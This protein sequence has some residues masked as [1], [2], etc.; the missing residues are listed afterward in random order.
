MSIQVGETRFAKRGSD[1]GEAIISGYSLGTIRDPFAS[2]GYCA[3]RKLYDVV[4]AD[5]SIGQIA[6]Q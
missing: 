6:A 3:Q 4:W 2:F 1:W 5:G